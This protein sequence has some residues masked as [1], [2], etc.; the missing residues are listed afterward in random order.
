[1]LYNNYI[2]F[3]KQYITLIF[4][5][6][7]NKVSINRNQLYIDIN[8]NFIRQFSLF[9]RDH[10]LA[11][12]KVLVDIVCIDYLS[13]SNR[14]ELC[15]LFLSLCYCSRV[16]IK[17]Y[18]NDLDRVGSLTFIFNNSNWYEREVWDLFG[19]FFN[20]HNDLRRILTDYGFKG[21][22]LRKDFPLSGYVEMVFDVETE[23]VKYIPVK[24]IQEFR[25]LSFKT[26]WG[27]KLDFS[28][29]KSSY[30]KLFLFR[31]VLLNSVDKILFSPIKQKL[32]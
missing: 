2:G 13:R 11:L 26:P 30:V 17:L 9:L 32:Y 6:F 19:V 22:P 8:Y 28:K 23:Q 18:L 31:E 21:F 12:F 29:I 27:Y 14:F 1:M 15:Y 10:S 16:N 3:F 4:P 20:Y 25:L 5:K 7:V 24:F